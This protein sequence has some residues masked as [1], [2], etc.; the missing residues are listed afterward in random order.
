MRSQQDDLTVLVS[1]SLF[2][3][4]LTKSRQR[5]ETTTVCASGTSD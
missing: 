4:L 2:R 1:V 3:G 5:G